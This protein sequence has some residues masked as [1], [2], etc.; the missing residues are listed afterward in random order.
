MG[1]YVAGAGAAPFF[2]APAKKGRS[3]RLRLH[4]TAQNNTILLVTPVSQLKK[5]HVTVLMA[6]PTFINLSATHNLIGRSFSPKNQR[7]L[8]PCFPYKSFFYELEPQF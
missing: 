7:R 2:T 4:N 6:R 1:S 5:T 3:G 8:L